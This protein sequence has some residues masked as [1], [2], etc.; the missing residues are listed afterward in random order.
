MGGLFHSLLDPSVAESFLRRSTVLLL[1]CFISDCSGENMVGDA[2]GV[3][4]VRLHALEVCISHGQFAFVTPCKT[5]GGGGGRERRRAKCH[6][7]T[8]RYCEGLSIT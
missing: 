1:S 4:P 6:P 7:Y 3:A 5:K 8:G 2:E